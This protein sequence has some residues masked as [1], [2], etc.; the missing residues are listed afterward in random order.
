M[1]TTASTRRSREKAGRRA[2]ALYF[3]AG[4]TAAVIGWVGS[5]ILARA[6]NIPGSTIIL[7]ITA[8]WAAGTALIATFTA[9]GDYAKARAALRGR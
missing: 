9:Q 1:F 2:L 6:L 7:A 3:A 5:A 8:A 4:Q